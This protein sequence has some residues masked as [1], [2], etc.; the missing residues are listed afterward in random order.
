MVT[1]SMMKKKEE[2]SLIKKQHKDE[3]ACMNS[4]S[5][6]ISKMDSFSKNFEMKLNSFRNGMYVFN[7]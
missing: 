3:M 5:M 1:P 6:N 4:I 2:I 7:K